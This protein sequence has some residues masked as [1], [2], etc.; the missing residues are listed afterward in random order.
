MWWNAKL[1]KIYI[2]NVGTN[3]YFKKGIILHRGGP[4]PTYRQ[5]VMIK[6]P[7]HDFGKI[8]LAKKYLEYSAINLVSEHLERMT[9]YVSKL[10]ITILVGTRAT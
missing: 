8:T 5:A 9:Y 10:N 1:K 3:F 7:W 4:G 2:P 6:H